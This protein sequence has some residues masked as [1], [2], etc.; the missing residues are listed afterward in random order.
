[1]E[2]PNPWVGP[3]L[4]VVNEQKYLTASLPRGRSPRAA[5]EGLVVDEGCPNANGPRA[6]HELPYFCLAGLVLTSGEKQASFG[7]KGPIIPLNGTNPTD[8]FHLIT[9]LLDPIA[10]FHRQLQWVRR[11]GYCYSP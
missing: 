3:P 10:V 7:F 6:S 2:E 1:M 8:G 9:L 5:D 4:S 11:C